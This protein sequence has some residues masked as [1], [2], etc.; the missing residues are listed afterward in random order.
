MTDIGPIRSALFVPATRLDRVPKALNSGADAVIVD[1][2]DAVPVAKKSE[3]RENLVAMLPEV[4][5][6]PV[7]VRVNSED[8]EFFADDIAQICSCKIAAIMIPK[9]ETTTGM[10]KVSKAL[11]DAEQLNGATHGSIKSIPLIETARAVENI[12]R[13]LQSEIEPRRI[14]TVAFGAADYTMDM[15]IEI[16]SEGNELAYARSRLAIACRVA[17]LEP[18]IDTPYMLNLKDLESLERDAVRAKQLGFQ[19]KLCIHPSQVG[20]VNRIFSPSA[21]D[22]ATAKRI[23]LAFEEAENQGQAAIQV[24]GK[25]VDYPVVARARRIIQAAALIGD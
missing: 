10:A 7:I 14:H 9:V 20:V 16:T 18:P 19:G 24:D 17:N 13:I 12:S 11:F 3:A 22:I 15:G 4:A 8:T 6:S 25:F 21:E 1:L 2:E 23:V 5:D